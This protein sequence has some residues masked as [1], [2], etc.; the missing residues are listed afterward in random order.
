MKRNRQMLFLTYGCCIVRSVGIKYNSFSD[1]NRIIKCAYELNSRNGQTSADESKYL[2]VFF[3]ASYLHVCFFLF[4]CFRTHV[5]HLFSFRV[6]H[7]TIHFFL[8][9]DDLLHIFIL[10]IFSKIKSKT[11]VTYYGF[12]R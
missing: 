5:S 1:K 2:F 10:V 9:F 6:L 12:H 3:F 8:R 7:H 11:K 4:C